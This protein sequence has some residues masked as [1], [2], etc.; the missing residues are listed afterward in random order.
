MCIRDRPNLL[1]EVKGVRFRAMKNPQ[2]PNVSVVLW[3]FP[4]N[5]SMKKIEKLIEES[6]AKYVK[7]LAP[8]TV[9]FVGAVTQ[10]FGETSF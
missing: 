10:Y 1:Q 6:I 8:K 9:H 5:E 2:T 7:T 3:E 4:N